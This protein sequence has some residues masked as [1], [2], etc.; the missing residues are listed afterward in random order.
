MTV[1]EIREQIRRVCLSLARSISK[2]AEI[3]GESLI[4]FSY[5]IDENIFDRIL[6]D[7]THE[8]DYPGE[9]VRTESAFH[10]WGPGNHT[11]MVVKVRSMSAEP[12]YHEYGLGFAL[13]E[14]LSNQIAALPAISIYRKEIKAEFIGETTEVHPGMKYPSCDHQVM[15][16][17]ATCPVCRSTTDRKAF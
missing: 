17:S 15:P 13:S 2:G 14:E 7:F 12:H 10:D 8:S 4:N 1:D 16:G 11:Q 6:M 3:N 9:T 5:L